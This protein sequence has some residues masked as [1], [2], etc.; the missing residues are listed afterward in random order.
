MAKW[1]DC[2]KHGQYQGTVAG[3]CPTCA[4]EL[5]R[6]LYRPAKHR[7]KDKDKEAKKKK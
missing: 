4:A 7:K 1:L 6:G 3:Q 5:G 2:P